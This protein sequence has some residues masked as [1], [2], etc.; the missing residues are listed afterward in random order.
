[1]NRLKIVLI[2]IFLTIFNAGINAWPIVSRTATNPGLFGYSNTRT[3]AI[4]YEHTYSQGGVEYTVY[5]MGY[6]ITCSDPGFSRCPKSVSL[7]RDP[8]TDDGWDQVQ[9]NQ[10]DDLMDFAFEQITNGNAS[11]THSVNIQ[12][13]GETFVRRYTVTW[14]GC[15]NSIIINRENIAF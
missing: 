6:V 1:M 7:Y 13:N 4:K 5:N 11:G 12:V 3:E 9:M 10:A 8:I 14:S 2:A 15:G